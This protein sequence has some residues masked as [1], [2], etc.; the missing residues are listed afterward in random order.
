MQIKKK[1]P[2]GFFK[3]QILFALFF[4]AHCAFWMFR[5][6]GEFDIWQVWNENLGHA[7]KRGKEVKDMFS[8]DGSGT[9][10]S[11]FGFLRHFFL[12]FA[13]NFNLQ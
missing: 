7:Q 11:G 9:R 5:W 10:N 13:K 3:K 8:S 4:L 12:H 1:K 2:L 6:P